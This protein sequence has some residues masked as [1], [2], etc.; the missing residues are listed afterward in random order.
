[1]YEIGE[2]IMFR[3]FVAGYGMG[4]SEIDS[5]PL[6]A[7]VVYIHPQRRYIVA[8]RR[9]SRGAYREA[10]ILKGDGRF[11]VDCNHEP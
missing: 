9:T 7:R 1:M 10:L 5:G 8:E 6:P 11:E 3:P 2:K 4:Q